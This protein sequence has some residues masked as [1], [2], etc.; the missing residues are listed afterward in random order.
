MKFDSQIHSTTNGRVCHCTKTVIVFC[1]VLA[2]QLTPVH[3]DWFGSLI[4]AL[5]DR[6]KLI[7]R[8][9]GREIPAP[10]YQDL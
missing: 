8:P 5:Y 6:E 3:P 10:M 1:V 7:F 2:L 9:I 4:D